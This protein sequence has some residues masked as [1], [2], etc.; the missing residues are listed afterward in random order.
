MTYF[1]Y[2]TK[3]CA[4]SVMKAPLPVWNK[5]SLEAP[6]KSKTRVRRVS[7]TNFL[8]KMSHFHLIITPLNQKQY[9]LPR[10]SLPLLSNYSKSLKVDQ[11]KAGHNFQTYKNSLH[12][13][14]SFIR[15]LFLNLLRLTPLPSRVFLICGLRT[16]ACLLVSHVLLF[17]ESGHVLMLSENIPQVMIFGQK[18]MTFLI[19]QKFDPVSFYVLFHVISLDETPWTVWTLVRFISTVYF[20]MPIQAAGVR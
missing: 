11:Q 5:C 18:F 15:V 14:Y 20:S 8:I 12:F 9:S 17:L 4:K 16:L 10:L 6:K 3:R 7:G 1:L 19:C 13:L 2:M